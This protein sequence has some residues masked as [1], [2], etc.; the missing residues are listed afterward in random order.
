MTIEKNDK[1]YISQNARFVF[2]KDKVAAFNNAYGQWIRFS[3]E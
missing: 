1:L 3:N 2:Y